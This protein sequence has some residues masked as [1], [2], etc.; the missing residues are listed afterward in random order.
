MQ[1]FLHN[2]CYGLEKRKNASRTDFLSSRE[3]GKANILYI[4]FPALATKLL[5][6]RQLEDLLNFIENYNFEEIFQP[7]IN[8]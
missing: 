5:N 7:P 2:C 8:T 1:D 4:C 3:Y 6:N